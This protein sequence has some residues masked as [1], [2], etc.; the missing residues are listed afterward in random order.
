MPADSAQ[1]DPPAGLGAVIEAELDYVYRH[2]PSPR[3]AQRVA[4]FEALRARAARVAANDRE[5]AVEGAADESAAGAAAPGEIDPAHWRDAVLSDPALRLTGLAFSGGGIR[6]ASFNLGVIQSL[7]RAGLLTKFDYMSGVSGGGYIL[8]WLLA[9]AYRVRGGLPAVQATLADGGAV[10][11]PSPI[12]HL[13]RYVTYLAPQS[14]L[15]ST[16]LWG[17]L[18]AYLRNLSVTITFALPLL[19]IPILLVHLLFAGLRFTVDGHAV[20]WQHLGFLAILLPAA[21]EVLAMRMFARDLTPSPAVDSARASRYLLSVHLAIGAPLAALYL[22]VPRPAL[23]WP[24]ALKFLAALVA[25]GA[26]NWIGERLKAE[27]VES[28]GIPADRRRVFRLAASALFSSIVF[29]AL[30]GAAHAWLAVAPG[31]SARAVA[32]SLPFVALVWSLIVA[33]PEFV[34]QFTVSKTMTD[35][36][37]EWTARFSGALLLGS[38]LWMAA[39]GGVLVLPAWLLAVDDPLAKAVALGAVG[40]AVVVAGWRGKTNLVLGMVAAGF[41]AA[42]CVRVFVYVDPLERI[43][44]LGSAVVTAGASV[45]VLA[46]I[47]VAFDRLVNINRFSLHAIYRNRLSRAFLG[48]SRIERPECADCPPEERPQ[49]RPRDPGLF[50]DYDADDNPRLRWLKVRDDG[51]PG[52]GWIP[53]ALFN[54]SLNSTW[55][56]TEAGRHETAFP[57]TFSQFFCGSPETGY[58]RARDYSSDEGGVSLATA[59]ATSGAALSSRS[60]RLDNRV[61]AFI[62]TVF[63]LRLGWWLGNPRDPVARTAAAPRYSMIAFCSELFGTSL[64]TRDWINLSDGGHFENLAVFELLQRGCARI[65]CVDASADP[66]RN[67]PDLATLVRLARAELNIDIV[68]EGPWRIGMPSLGEQGRH[69]ALFRVDYPNG[70]RG[71]LLY[72]KSALYEGGSVAPVDAVSYHREHPAF[73]HESTVDQF[74]SA[75]QFESYRRLGEE[76]MRALVGAAPGEREIDELFAGAAMHLDLSP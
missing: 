2:A 1:T 11:E 16:D 72:V 22:L 54:A 39:V 7:A 52:S 30:T 15:M 67:C 43:E 23:D 42:I 24:D 36:D 44:A 14:G 28:A 37:R 47:V 70:R 51:P 57:F 6:S 63:N 34:H 73:P 5:P 40:L 33:V 29:V 55:M 20:W 75:A 12:R 66:A 27:R 10:R 49:F 17:L 41:A 45:V 32:W 3:Q 13:R 64:R 8:G 62:K 59:M 18:A 60:G 71:E 61:L 68:R 76:T 38:L 46:V 50:Q 48:A 56:I 25:F 26:V 31:S 65:V 74:F 19:L 53:P 58:C 69:C 35:A 4:A 9:W 21:V